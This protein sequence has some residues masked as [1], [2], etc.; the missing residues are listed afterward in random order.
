MI[1][2]DEKIAKTRAFNLDKAILQCNDI[3]LPFTEESLAG[4]RLI[5][6]ATFQGRLDIATALLAK[7]A[8]C[9][10]PIALGIFEGCTPLFTAASLGYDK[11]VA[12]FIRNKA[13]FTS[14][15][16]E[17]KSKGCTPLFSAAYS[18]ADKVVALLIENKADFTSALTEGQFKGDTPLFIAAQLGRGKVV[19]LFIKNKA[20]FT[21]ALTE[22][23]HKGLTPLFVAAHGG[24]YR[25]VV[26]FIESKVNFTS[27]ITEGLFK[28]KT[29]LSIASFKNHTSVMRAIL[30]YQL[31]ENLLSNPIAL[32]SF[33]FDYPDTKIN[34]EIKIIGS[35][36]LKSLKDVIKLH[37]IMTSSA[38][39]TLLPNELLT[40]IAYYHFMDSINT[41]V[42]FQCFSFLAQ[43][44]L[45]FNLQINSLTSTY[46][47]VKKRLHLRNQDA[48]DI[49]DVAKPSTQ[50]ETETKAN[51]EV[52]DV[53]NKK[54]V[55]DNDQA[56]TDDP[57]QPP[58]K[59]TKNETNYS[60]L[61]LFATNGDRNSPPRHAPP[62]HHRNVPS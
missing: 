54:R 40:K 5:D 43:A 42:T 31:K 27:A 30:I 59:K 52:H 15:L 44:Y 23:L 17:G 50:L 49:D 48:M 29:A 36:L 46:H 61:T 51:T 55:R 62:T 2:R 24:H 9:H 6:I 16:T 60:A 28:D 21:S 58:L 1:S 56:A 4:L 22:G 47:A 25:V 10:K 35:E 19:A 53:S 3:N 12:L 18:G 32:M 34:D 7:G 13:N 57:N 14:A 39:S 20:D 45:R 33:G 41:V 26:L 11:L 37:Y 38:T 8:D